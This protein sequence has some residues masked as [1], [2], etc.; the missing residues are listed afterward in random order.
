MVLLRVA[1]RMKPIVMISMHLSVRVQGDDACWTRQ[2]QAPGNRE[3]I[4]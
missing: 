1:A 2:Q 3:G 4:S